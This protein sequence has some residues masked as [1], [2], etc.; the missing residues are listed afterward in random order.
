[1]RHTILLFSVFA[2]LC[3]CATQNTIT[4]GDRDSEYV[5]EIGTEAV[6]H[7]VVEMKRTGNYQP[8]QD[9]EM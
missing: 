5:Q 2:F 7:R 4:E 6:M 8:V 1:M 9:G 3:G